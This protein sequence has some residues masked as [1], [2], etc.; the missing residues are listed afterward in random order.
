MNPW[1]SITAADYDGHMGPDG[2]DQLGPLARIFGEI[3]G[4]VRPPSV[5]LLGCATG[6]GLEA[7]EPAV[8]SRVVGIDLNPEYLALARARHAALGEALDLRCADLLTCALEPAGFALVHAALVFEHLDPAALAARIAGWLAPDGLCSVVL[9]AAA[10]G[11]A[12]PLVSRTGFPSLAALSATMRLVSPSELSRLFA[13]HGLAERRAWQVP[14]RDGKAFHA[15]IY[16]RR[17]S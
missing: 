3:V 8:T 14:L 1:L 4:E 7:I 2:A 6:N 10:R 17:P 5:A 13:A 9:Q 16:G 15:A 11:E 12:P